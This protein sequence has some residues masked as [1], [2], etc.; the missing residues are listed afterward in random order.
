MNDL[1]WIILL[2]QLV[3]QS[4]FLAKN[5][6]LKRRLGG[7]IRG[8]NL[9]ANLAIGLFIAFIACTLVIAFRF[10]APGAGAPLPAAVTRTGGLSLMIAS[11][12][13]ARSALKD[14]G[15]AWRIG[16]I[17]GSHTEL[18]ERGIYRFSRNPF[19]L[20][21]LVSFAAYGIV[22]QSAALLGLLLACLAATHAMILKEEAF[23][24]GSHGN[25]YAAYKQRVP[26][27]IGLRALW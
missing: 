27:Y 23:L 3:F 12:L 4:M 21:Y 19:F 26:R 16:V 9:E 8:N 15:D 20:A 22:L 6:R 2:H 5:I 18:V 1:P 13:L 14:L 25:L 7:P 11:L 10:P 17:E 24:Q